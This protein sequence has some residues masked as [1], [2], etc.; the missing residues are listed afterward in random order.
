MK[1]ILLCLV[2][3]TLS[4][5]FSQ[6]NRLEKLLLNSP[7]YFSDL[8]N[9]PEKYR[10]QIIYTQIDRDKNNFAHFKTFEYRVNENEYFYPASTV[11]LAASVLALGKINSLK[12][13]GVNKH[14]PIINLKNR[15][16]Q[17]ESRI[18]ST[19][20][21]KLPSVANYIK[22]IF[23]VSDNDAYN[24]LYELLG[25]NNF[26]EEMSKKGFSG[27][28]F[29]HRLQLPLPREEN[30]ITNPIFIL[31][32]KD[33]SKIIWMQDEATNKNIIK[34]PTEILLG[35]GF[36][37]DSGTVSLQPFD[38]TYR[39]SFP[40]KAQHEFLQRLFFPEVFSKEKQFNLTKDD[41]Q[42]IYKYMSMFPQESKFPVFLVD[43]IYYPTSCKFIFYGSDKKIIP[44]SNIRI[45]NKIGGAY[46]FLLDNAYF[47]DFENKIEFIVSAVILCNEDEIFND[48]KYDY[49]KVGYPFFKNLGKVLYDYELNRE[50]EFLPDLSKF[51]FNYLE[52]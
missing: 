4:Q 26:N 28:R 41:Y 44:D 10:V 45:F 3:I 52:N 6:E 36:M 50:K 40:I 35:K 21:N 29:T 22:K 11:K 13:F 25:Q 19:S 51:K 7:Q 39:N 27:V 18:D 24:R 38:F 48:D 9:N 1:K 20:E 47:V 30:R 2:F 43:S 14:S 46:G 34:S 12:K 31:N 15:N 49:E 16:L 42:F 37:D 33:T 5:L 8:T 23:L 17:I 32:N